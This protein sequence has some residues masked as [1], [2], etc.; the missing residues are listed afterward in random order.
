M[1]EVL[2]QYAAYNLWANQKLTEAILKLDE[3]LYKQPVASSFPSLHAT[4]LHMWDAESVW[5]QRMKLYEK[6]AVPSENSSLSMQEVV[7]GLLQQNKLW[8]EWVG[9]ATL[10]ALEHVFAYQ[11]SKREQFKQ[12]VYQMVH[13]IFNHGTYH[14][15][16]LVT[17]MRTLGIDKIPQTDFII[18]SRKNK[19]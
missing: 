6:I 14:R 5:W 13:H 19:S 12:P 15:G 9:N 17:M 2:Q 8:E 4:S 7:N 3:A 11:N 16:Q 18:W 1:K 10:P